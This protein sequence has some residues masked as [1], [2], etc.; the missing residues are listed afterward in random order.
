MGGWLEVEASI[1]RSAEV[2]RKRRLLSWSFGFLIEGIC[3]VYALL[4]LDHNKSCDIVESRT[5][6]LLAISRR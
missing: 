3:F 6:P 5:P 1:S 4:R 2:D